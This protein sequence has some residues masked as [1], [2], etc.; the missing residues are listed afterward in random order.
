[1]NRYEFMGIVLIL[2]GIILSIIT[3]QSELINSFE[4]PPILIINILI[5]FF[6]GSYIWAVGKMEI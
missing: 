5:S 2:I 6:V 4:I 3:I 1:M